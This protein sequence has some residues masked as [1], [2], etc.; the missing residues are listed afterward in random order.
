MPDHGAS[1]ALGDE[2]IYER[3]R[4]G[5]S[6]LFSWPFMAKSVE[7]QYPRRPVPFP[8]CVKLDSLS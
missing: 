6:P 5:A 8:L 4:S 1:R 2:L 7:Q 3:P